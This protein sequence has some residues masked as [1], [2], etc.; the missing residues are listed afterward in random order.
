MH[1]DLSARGDYSLDTFLLKEFGM[2]LRII[3][4]V[5]ILIGIVVAYSLGFFGQIG[6]AHDLLGILIALLE[7][8]IVV[9]AWPLFYFHIVSFG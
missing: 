2:L 9:V 8:L 4:I 6:A 7:A 5:Y 3:E 1:K